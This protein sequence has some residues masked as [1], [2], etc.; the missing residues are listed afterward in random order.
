MIKS[1]TGGSMVFIASMS[2]HI[3]NWQWRGHC[4]AMNT[5]ESPGG[6]NT[7]EL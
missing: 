1:T 6:G 5:M 3:V 4:D 2:G 7:L